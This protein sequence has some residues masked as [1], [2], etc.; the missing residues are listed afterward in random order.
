VN[1]PIKK[2]KMRVVKKVLSYIVSVIIVILLLY[3]YVFFVIIVP[4]PSMHPTILVG[5]RIL[6]TRIHNTSS[7]K[8]GDILVFYSDELKEAM[9][10]RVIGLPNEK[11]V[12][13]T[14]GEVFVNNQKLNEPYVK[15]NDELSGT[16]KVPDGEYFFLGDFREHSHDSRK[17]KDPY[18]PKNK[19]L[20][21]AKLILFPLQRMKLI[22]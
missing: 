22:K 8:R 21:Q 4:S 5:D 9:V 2:G 1:K 14:K 17:W 15:Y 16:F 18:I 7:I 12:I 13:N 19:I 20:G 6:T 3:N 11:I 10:K